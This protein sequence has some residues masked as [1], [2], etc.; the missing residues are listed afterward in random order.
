MGDNRGA[1]NDS[2]YWGP[3]PADRIIGSAF[4]RYW[5]PDR[6]GVP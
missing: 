2:R 1:S 4:V 5:P 6:V 3:L